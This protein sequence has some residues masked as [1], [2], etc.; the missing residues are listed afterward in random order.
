MIMK[1]WEKFAETLDITKDLKETYHKIRKVFQREGWTEKDLKNPPYYPTDLMKNFQKF[2]N[3][4]DEIFQTIRDYGFDID[5]KGV[6][7][8]IQNKLR[9]IDDITTLR[10]PD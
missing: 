9:P 4:R 6:T 5:H 7:D 1:G 8:Y 10:D 3:Q 2:S